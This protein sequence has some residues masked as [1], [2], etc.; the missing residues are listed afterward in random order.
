M[1][2]GYNMTDIISEIKENKKR[3]NF[4]GIEFSSIE[5]FK[6]QYPDLKYEQGVDGFGYLELKITD[7]DGD[8]VTIPVI[9][10]A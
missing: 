4:C 1:K 6:E 10:D 5:S 8:S 2:M 7:S 9:E 3:P